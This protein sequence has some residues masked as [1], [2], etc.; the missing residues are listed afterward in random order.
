MAIFHE[1]PYTN[2]HDLNLDWIIKIVKELKAIVDSIDVDEINR[3]FTNIETILAEHSADI[4]LLKSQST[5]AAAAISALQTTVSSMEVDI[6]QIHS[7]IDGVIDQIAAAVSELTGDVTALETDLEDYKTATNA[8]LKNV[9]DAAFDPSQIVMSN[10]PFNFAISTLNGNKY[11]IRIVADEAVSSQDS[12]QWVDGGDYA[13]GGTATPEK[14]KFRSTFKIPRFFNSGNQ[15]HM[16]IPNIFPIKYAA[17]INWSLY[18]YANR[19]IGPTSGNVGICK[20]GP[21]NFTDLLAEGGYTIATNPDANSACFNSMELFANEETGCYDLHIYNGRNGKYCWIQNYFFTSLMI[22]PLDLGTMSQTPSIQKYFN[23]LN[24]Y[25]TQANS[26][27]DSK[28]TSAVAQ[29]Q[30]VLEDLISASHDSGLRAA[31]VMNPIVFNED[32]DVVTSITRNYSKY[33]VQRV[34]DH[35]GA[36]Y[37]Y[38]VKRLYVD[39]T[40]VLHDVPDSVDVE[41]GQFAVGGSVPISM[42]NSGLVNI[43]ANAGVPLLE[44]Y[45]SVG[46]DGTLAMHLKGATPVNSTMTVRINGYIEVVEDNLLP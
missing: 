16:V 10:Y 19:W 46:A 12:I 6:T 44:E 7:Q 28:I 34:F 42:A 2:F 35:Y 1:Y 14:Q 39:L 32:P 5:S 40:M 3:R 45:A 8:R 27:I 30:S 4:A 13:P 24:T 22:L 15:C 11:G 38:Y 41:L 18:F 23:L 37:D 26:N 31:I 21:I 25:L 36:S 29:S 20:V 17:N 33:S 9:E 43:A